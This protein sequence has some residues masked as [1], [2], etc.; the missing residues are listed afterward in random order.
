[1]VRQKASP[2]A[3]AAAKA[4]FAAQRAKPKTEPVT[5]RNIAQQALA[6]TVGTHA[7]IYMLG[8]APLAVLRSFK[9]AESEAETIATLKRV[10][11]EAIA[12]AEAGHL[13][14]PLPA[15]P[16]VEAQP[17]V[18]GSKTF[19][20]H[21]LYMDGEIRLQNSKE[22]EDYAWIKR[23]ELAKYVGKEQAEALSKSLL[24]ARQ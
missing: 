20:M 19:F 1:M 21:A 9:N 2:T 24:D 17:S 22:Y 3:I 12:R 8:N 5:V 13:A 11:D 4:Q 14:P 16:A 23:D 10:K 15:A 6:G 7:S 18:V